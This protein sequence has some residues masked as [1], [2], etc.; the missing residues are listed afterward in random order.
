MLTGPKSAGLE[1]SARVR[2]STL[3]PILPVPQESL[4]TGLDDRNLPGSLPGLRTG[5]VVALGKWELWA[6]ISWYPRLVSQ[7]PPFG[8]T[9]TASLKRESTL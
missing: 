6:N 5:S 2:L 1:T 9:R 7:C 4:K 3:S 8:F